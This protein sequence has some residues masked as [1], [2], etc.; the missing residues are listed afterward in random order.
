MIPNNLRFYTFGVSLQVKVWKRFGD[1]DFQQ[2]Y[3][4]ELKDGKPDAL[5]IAS[6]PVGT[7]Y[8]GEWKNGKADS[9]Q[10]IF[11][12]PNGGKYVG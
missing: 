8:I 9:H 7:K 3:N 1:D 11:T 10:G 4:G 12:L 5:G 6:H 2:K